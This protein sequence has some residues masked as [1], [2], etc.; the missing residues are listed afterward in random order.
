MNLDLLENFCKEKEIPFKKGEPMDRHTTFR[1]GGKADAMLWPNSAE[2]MKETLL[3]CREQKIPA[4]VIGR[5]SNLLVSDDGVEGAVVS[6][7]GL[8][9]LEITGQTVTAEAGVPL[10]ALAA[11]AAK[12]G[13]SGL[14]FAYG[15]PGSVG[16]ALCMNAGAY[17]SEVRDVVTRAGAVDASGKVFEIPVSEMRLS[18]RASRFR[19]EGLTVLWARFSLQPGNPEGITEKMQEFLRRRREKQPL[20][21]PSA[22]STFKRPEG[23]FAGALIEQNGWKG[24]G[25]GDAVVSEKH[26]GFVINRGHATAR[27]ILALIQKIEDSVLKHDGVRLEPEVIFLGRKTEKSESSL[28]TSI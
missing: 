3:F 4:A 2:A 16:G 13:L 1:V 26:A 20:E 25:V 12:A 27:E 18:Y 5:G 19:A 22:G 8:N 6:T 11:A 23:R 28:K 15:I 14:E 21:Y 24:K 17:G 10:S 7:D 9:R